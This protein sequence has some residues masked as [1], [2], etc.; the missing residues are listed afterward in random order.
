MPNQTVVKVE[1]KLAF[2]KVDKKDIGCKL[3]GMWTK[4]NYSHVEII[5]KDLWISSTLEGGVHIKPLQPLKDTYDYYDIEVYVTDYQYMRIMEWVYKQNKKSYDRL[6]IMFS[7]FIPFRFDSRSK[8]FCSELVCKILQLFYVQ[9]VMD[10]Y[11][12][13]TSPGDLAKIYKLE[14]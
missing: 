3:I 12:F 5:I 8:W 14:Y 1:L 6:G 4:S 13:L 9:E 11:P 10:L 7:Q 2:K